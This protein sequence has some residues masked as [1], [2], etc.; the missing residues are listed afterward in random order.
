MGSEISTGTMVEGAIAGILNK[1][2]FIQG[3]IT[4][5]VVIV[6]LLGLRFSL[7]HIIKGKKEI[8]DKEQRRWINRVKNGTGIAIIL[9]IVLIWAPQLQTFAL[10]LTAVAVAIAL[11]TKELLMCLTGGFLRASTNSFDV[12]D[13]VKI[14]D[15]TGEVV[16]ITAM[17]TVLEEVD[18]KSGSYE[19]TGKTVQFSNSRFLSGSVENINLI[20][21]YIYHSFTI[22]VPGLEFEPAMLM[23]ELAGIARSYYI[24]YS[25]D[26]IKH[27][28]RV[29]RKTGIDYPDPEPK[30]YLKTAD[31]GHFVFTVMLFVPTTQ[32]ARTSSHITRDFLAYYY[33]QKSVVGS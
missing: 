33:G 27:N 14:D 19:F 17:A 32:A 5:L 26:A 4:S 23:D 1:Q 7:V 8:L 11:S 31:S 10:S 13:W 9:A 25:E 22:T 28:K 18:A 12:G 15:I 29:E 30:I 6:L 3:G 24:S 2:L 21:D 20:K 16:R